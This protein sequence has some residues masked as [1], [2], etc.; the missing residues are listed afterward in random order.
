MGLIW[1]STEATVT[2]RI[3]L[4]RKIKLR[5]H[6]RYTS[7]NKGVIEDGYSSQGMR[8]EDIK[9]LRSDR[10]KVITE[11]H[12][13]LNEIHDELMQSIVEIAVAEVKSEL[14]SPPSRFA[15][16]LMGSAGRFEQSFWSDQDHGIIYEK[17]NNENANYFIRLGKEISK[18]LSICDYDLCDGKVMASNPL[19]CKS[20]D[21]WER[22]VSGWLTEDSWQS[23]R[24][25]SILFDSRVLV[26]ESDFLR[27]LKDIIFK[28]LD[29]E[30]N[31]IFRLLDNVGYVKKG[32]G[33]FGQLLP[34]TN[35]KGKGHIH[36]KEKILF[37]YVNSV[38]LLAF[39]ERIYLPSTLSR[40]NHLTAFYKDMKEYEETFHRILELRLHFQK[41]LNEDD[42]VNLISIEALSSNEK[43]EIKIMMKN[44]Y[45][46]F[47]KTKGIIQQRG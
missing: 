6:N 47:Q 19:W 35:S 18:G 37:P 10:I 31:I 27:V 14:G 26:G 24:N 44:G 7:I 41:R 22:Q 28:R 17:S 8:Y 15:F 12:I 34:E 1:Q 46:L 5:E 13:L 36:I 16:F 32:I 11:D 39:K 29:K 38:R 33:F 30:Q 21:E 42:N 9:E 4:L 23:L 45:K 43:K 2:Q 20:I 3:C 25:I 40:F